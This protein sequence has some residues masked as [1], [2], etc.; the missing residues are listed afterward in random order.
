MIFDVWPHQST[1]R[2]A[3]V[4][5]AII[6]HF[7]MAYTTYLR[8]FLGVVYH[9]YT[10]FSWH[11]E[12]GTCW[13][14]L[15]KGRFFQTPTEFLRKNKKLTSDR[16]SGY[17]QVVEHSYQKKD[18]LAVIN[19]DNLHYSQQLPEQLYTG[20]CDA[21]WAGAAFLLTDLPKRYSGA[22][23]LHVYD[24]NERLAKSRKA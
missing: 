1:R 11:S 18:T 19:A 10:Q 22:S 9:C 6:N 12:G 5:I 16:C 14:A 13:K 3:N 2:A 15:A 17:K 23:S 20:Q 4:G 8:W 7:G 24:V 21:V